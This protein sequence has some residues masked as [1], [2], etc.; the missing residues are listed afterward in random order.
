MTRKELREELEA[1]GF[2][3]L[4]EARLN[5]FI[6]SAYLVDICELE[7]WPFLE[8]TK[9]GKAPLEISDLRTVEYILDTTQ[10]CKLRPVLRARLTDDWDVDL[11]TTGDPTV[12]YLTEG[13]KVNVYPANTTDNLLVRYWKVAAEL[14]EDSK[15]PISPARFHPLIVDFAEARAYRDK[16]NSDAAN[17]AQANADR[18]LQI[19]RESLLNQQHDDSDDYVTV[20]DVA[21]L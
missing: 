2:D 15:E 14:T 18:Q 13:K 1:R 8:A 10:E 9:E 16:N 19:M 11:T 4:T 7:D 21:A 3:Y 20:E 17:A 5:R 6:N 12:Y